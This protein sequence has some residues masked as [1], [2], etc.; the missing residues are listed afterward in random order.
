LLGS[1]N[2]LEIFGFLALALFLMG[3]TFAP[4]GAILPELFPTR[5]RYTGSSLATILGAFSAHRWLPTLLNALL[6]SEA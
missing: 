3:I 2:Y 4:L 6:S 5:L 1:V